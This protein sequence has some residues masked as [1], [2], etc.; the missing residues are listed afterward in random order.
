MPPHAGHLQLIRAAVEQ[1]D[2]LTLLVSS[3]PH[4]PI[5]G[6]MR[7]AWM[8]ELVGALSPMARVVHVHGD[9]PAQPADDPRFWEIWLGIL[10]QVMPV[11]PDL[12]FTGEAY[13]DELARRLGA[14]HVRIDR[15]TATIPISAT[16]IRGDPLAHWDL[17][18]GPVRPWFVKRV[19][20][21]GSESTGKTML[22]RDLAAHFGTVWVPEFARA[23][24]D[25]KLAHRNQTLDASDIEPIARGQA[26]AEDAGARAANRVLFLDTN[27]LSTELYARHYYRACP[28][29]IGRAATERRADLYLLTDIDVPWIADTQRDHPHMRAHMHALFIDSL[30]R[31]GFPYVTIS[32]TFGDRFQLAVKATRELVGSR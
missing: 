18:P 12:V 30:E 28:D 21:I 19:V 5:P 23:Y 13:G 3:L 1:V 14:R 10:R 32:G 22:A 27:L 2:A 6:A 17:I 31:R 7:A 29:W 26:A 9:N 16:M 24:L 15:G 20:V 8:R 25:A 4:E 11:G